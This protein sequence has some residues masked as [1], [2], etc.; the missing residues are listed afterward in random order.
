MTEKQDRKEKEEEIEKLPIKQL[1]IQRI[2]WHI[3]NRREDKP[4]NDCAGA[5]LESLETE[6]GYRLAPPV[7]KKLREEVAKIIWEYKEPLKSQVIG[8]IISL[9]QSAQAEAVRQHHELLKKAVELIKTWHNGEAVMKLGKEQA[10]YMWNIYYNNAPEM[11]AIR[12]AL[13]N[14]GKQIEA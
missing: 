2:C 4:I 12:Q 13:S 8:D 10:E 3:F 7:D 6:F 9:F 14:E 5:I 11:K 1:A